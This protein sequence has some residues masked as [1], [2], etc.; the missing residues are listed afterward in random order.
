MAWLKNDAPLNFVS[1]DPEKVLETIRKLHSR[2]TERFPD[3]GLAR[4][5]ADLEQVCARS[6]KRIQWIAAPIWPLRIMRYAIICGVVIGLGITFFDLRP[7]ELVGYDTMER[8]QFFESG[9]N[10]LLLLSAALFFIW[11]LESRIKRSRALAAIHELR[12]IAHVIDMH[13]LTKDPDR[14]LESHKSTASSP[15]NFESAFEL[16][17]YLDY[18]TEM[19]ALVSTVAARHLQYLN[20]TAVVGAVNEV[21][22]L[23]NGLSRKIWQKINML[24][25]RQ[26]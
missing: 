24:T 15:H 25:P 10:N 7:A 13:Q 1:L 21:E 6:T 4:V 19:L 18:C 8:L 22:D 9:I 14:L 17:R 12:S 2:I 26:N 16:R 5:C 11:T 3:A 23:T 20:D